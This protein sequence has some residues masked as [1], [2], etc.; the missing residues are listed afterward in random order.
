MN[1]LPLFKGRLFGR[2]GAEVT[3]DESRTGDNT[4]RSR[5]T[6]IARGRS[7]P[8]SPLSQFKYEL[9]STLPAPASGNYC[10]IVPEKSGIPSHKSQNYD[11]V[12][13]SV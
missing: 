12:N 10:Q 8:N 3:L 13:L 7:S 9:V 4:T 5:A 11:E 2:V 6:S 1:D